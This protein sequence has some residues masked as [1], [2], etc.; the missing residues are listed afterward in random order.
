MS[1]FDVRVFAVRR[2]SGRAA[3]EVRWRVAGRDRSRSFM[4]RALADSYRAELVRAARRGLAFD[5]VTGEPAAWATPEPA[6]VTWY[7]HAG[8]YA[9][10][11]WPHLAP[12]SRAS[13][14]DALATITPLL[15]RE[16]SRRPPDG[17][18][19]AALYGYAFNPQRRS[20][21]PDPATA[22]T[23]E[24]LERA[25]LPLSQLSDPQ[26]IRAALDGLCTRLDGSPA[27]ANTIARKRAAFHGV[28]GYA[29][30]RGLLPAN[31]LGLVRWHAPAAAT[32]VNPATVA[33]PAQ[34][35]AILDHAARERP[36]LVAFF[37]CLYY[38]AL[39]PEE[40]VALRREDLILP[41]NGHGRIILTAACPRTGTA[42]T[43]TGTPHE[44]RGLK[45]RPDG[46]IRVVPI[47][48]VLARMLRRHLRQFGTAPDGRLFPGTRGGILS[49]SVYGRAWHAARL[50]ALGPEL[51]VTALARRPYDL[52]HAAL[53]LWLNA[54]NAPA[55]VAARAGNSARVLHEVYLHCIDSQEDIVSQRIEE[56]LDTGTS[57]SLPPQCVKAS[58]CAHRRLPRDPV[59]YVS[60]NLRHR[61]T[62]GPR[63]P[64]RAH[65]DRG[66]PASCRPTVSTAHTVLSGSTLDVWRRPDLAH[67]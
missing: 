26:V 39:R 7:Q 54:T 19:R 55:E 22:S 56:A 30:E 16:I 47:P 23:L 15:T 24:W 29:V 8:A 38:A 25:S 49:E 42:W 20:R 62:H 6:A 31:P 4:T 21:A 14:A 66:R 1:S 32:A 43:G 18:L 64:A 37:G 9:E 48:P 34:V 45:H 5:P 60:V 59:R 28:L 33:S 36:V 44:P 51:A 11:K 10:M 63:T 57:S 46:A 53:S 13:L 17:T 61:P 52:R 12:H 50:A 58:S 2:R 41:E 40:A 65:Q 27:S 3:F 67:A 35:R